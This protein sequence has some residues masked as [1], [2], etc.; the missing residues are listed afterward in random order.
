MP[1]GEISAGELELLLM[2]MTPAEVYRSYSPASY[3]RGTVEAILRRLD[4]DTAGK[5]VRVMRAEQAEIHPKARARGAT[6]YYAPCG[7]AYTAGIALSEWIRRVFRD[8]YV[9][10]VALRRN[11]AVN[12]AWRADRELCSWEDVRT[13]LNT[14]IFFEPYTFPVYTSA[15]WAELNEQYHKHVT[16]IQLAP[17]DPAGYLNIAADLGQ[18][19]RSRLV[20]LLSALHHRGY[21]VDTE[22]AAT[23]GGT[24]S[25]RWLCACAHTTQPT[26]GLLVEKA[27]T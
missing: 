6:R 26:C 5:L 17:S 12:D 7:L 21:E 4:A 10:G 16:S 2:T 11:L 20:D 22:R 9:R 3:G 8:H 13:L 14:K 24:R 1:C 19:K 15:P 18:L 25:P 27:F 23:A